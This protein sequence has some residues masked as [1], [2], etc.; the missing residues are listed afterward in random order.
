MQRPH[1]SSLAVVVALLGL[2]C[3]K[4]SV[5]PTRTVLVGGPQQQP[6]RVL[7]YNFAVSEEEVH[8][9][10]A[11]G[12]AA[13]RFLTGDPETSA[14]MELGHIAA[15]ALANTMTAELNKIGIAASR[16]DGP[17]PE[18]GEVLLLNG[19]FLDIDEGNRLARTV[20]GFGAGATELHTRVEASWV[21][22]GEFEKLGEARTEATGSKKPGLVV[23]LGVGAATDVWM[24]VAIV[25]AGTAILE[26]LGPLE[27]NIQ[28][29]AE[30]VALFVG[31]RYVERGWLPA[32]AIDQGFFK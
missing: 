6:D 14:E 12:A 16:A 32:E 8:L 28:D 31:Q 11:P 22:E 7:V 25:G 23:P 26:A 24:G 2:A 19:E 17:P 5:Q 18:T 21:R 1:P 13:A 15:A 3:A 20:V 29:T 27:A 30:Q 4:A 9:N 10:R